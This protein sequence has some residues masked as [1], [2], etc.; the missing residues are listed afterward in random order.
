M[1]HDPEGKAALAV[2]GGAAT[3]DIGAALI[4]DHCAAERG[5][6]GNTGRQVPVEYAEP[7]VELSGKLAESRIDLGVE[8]AKPGVELVEIDCVGRGNTRC[9][10]GDAP[11]G[12]RGSDRYRVR[13]VGD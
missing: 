5:G 8:L 1:V 3:A 12:A 13:L 7:R 4:G 10:V 6:L 11:L 2:V 9:D